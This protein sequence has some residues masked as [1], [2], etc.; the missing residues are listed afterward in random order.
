MICDAN[1]GCFKINSNVTVD[2]KSEMTHCVYTCTW[3]ANTKMC[4]METIIFDAKQQIWTECVGVHH[5][6]LY[7]FPRFPLGVWDIEG[8]Y[9]DMSQRKARKML[10]QKVDTKVTRIHKMMRVLPRPRSF[11]KSPGSVSRYWVAH[12]NGTG[13]VHTEQNNNNNKHKLW[14]ETLVDSDEKQIAGSVCKIYKTSLGCALKI[15]AMWQM[16]GD[17]RALYSCQ[18]LER[19]RHGRDGD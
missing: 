5:N 16:L 3:V 12:L 1:W 10:R 17:L 2:A 13:V 8:R 11:T 19:T 14:S 6:I 18:S 7:H 4:S 9:R 15:T